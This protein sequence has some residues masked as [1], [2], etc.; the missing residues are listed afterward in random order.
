VR[1]NVIRLPGTDEPRTPTLSRSTQTQIIEEVKAQLYR[2]QCAWLMVFD[3]LEDPEILKKYAPRGGK[4]GHILI[5]TRCG[6]SSPPRPP[7]AGPP[8]AGNVAHCQAASAL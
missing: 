4:H 2:C 7:P 8:A 3:N 5:T 1:R 6:P